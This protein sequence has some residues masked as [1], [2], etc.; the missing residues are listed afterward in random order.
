M[1]TTFF[2][3]K[4]SLA[5]LGPELTLVRYKPY[6]FGNWIEV[7]W[8]ELDLW[9]L[10]KLEYF[11]REKVSEAWLRRL[12]RNCQGLRVATRSAK[13]FINSYFEIYLFQF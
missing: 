7:K 13:G 4:N 11:Q 12:C 2:Y 9:I 8:M 5:R 1:K 6:H 3:F 10:A